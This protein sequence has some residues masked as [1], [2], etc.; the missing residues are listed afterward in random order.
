MN[1]YNLK[2]KGRTL[3]KFCYYKCT[4]IIPVFHSWESIHENA[5]ALTYLPLSPHDKS[6]CLIVL[7]AMMDTDTNKH[8]SGRYWSV[9]LVELLQIHFRQKP[10]IIFSDLVTL[11]FDLRP[12]TYNLNLAKVKVNS[13]TKNQGHRSNGLAVRV[14][15]EPRLRF[16]YLDCW[17]GRYKH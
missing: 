9:E 7:F 15:T 17:C 16:Y 1:A 2:S 11:T 4:S 12:L 10:E 6:F 5:W 14:R 13:H 8:I 3:T